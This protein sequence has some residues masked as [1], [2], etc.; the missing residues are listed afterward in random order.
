MIRRCSIVGGKGASIND[1]RT[2]GGEGG[3]RNADKIRGGYVNFIIQISSQRGEEVG[4][5]V[6]KSKKIADVI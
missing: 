4:N 6:N 5:W 1:V 3:H 2:R